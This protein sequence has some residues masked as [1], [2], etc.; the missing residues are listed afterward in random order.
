ML[1]IVYAVLACG[2]FLVS[3]FC[4]LVL[5]QYLPERHRDIHTVEFIR[6]AIGALVT[7][8]AIVLGLLTASSKQHFDNISKSYR[9]MA[10]EIVLLDARL[11]EVGSATAPIR[12]E[13]RS[14]LASVVFSTWPDEPPPS[15]EYLRGLPAGQSESIQLSALLGHVAQQIRDLVPATPAQA[16]ALAAVTQ[17]FAAFSEAR[18]TVIETDHPTIPTAFYGLMLFWTSLMF[19]GFGLC[20]PRNAVVAVTVLICAISLASVIFV[21]LELEDSSAGLI[22]ISSRP[23]RAVLADLDRE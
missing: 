21:I 1:Q 20:A 19:V 11:R 6:L 5:C 10:A 22:A 7:F 16:A 8:L 4:G 17:R 23:L 18:W 2:L 12:A 15:G 14:Y 3:G 13:L 9:H